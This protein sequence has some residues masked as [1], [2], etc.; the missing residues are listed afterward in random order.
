MDNH[1]RRHL[2]PAVTPLLLLA[3]L[4]LASAVVTPSA[5]AQDQ[6]RPVVA[7]VRVGSGPAGVAY[8]PAKGEVFVTDLLNKTVSVVS[9]ATNAVVATVS[10][11]RNP[12][13]GA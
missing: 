12:A 3:A 7:T 9:D 5:R 4:I 8:D 10:V 13:G 1:R 2:R 11:G 6:A